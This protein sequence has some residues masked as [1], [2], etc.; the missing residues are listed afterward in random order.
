[1]KY[2]EGE[3]MKKYN[4]LI[5]NPALTHISWVNELNGQDTSRG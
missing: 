1:M 5:K 3:Q 4:K 2:T